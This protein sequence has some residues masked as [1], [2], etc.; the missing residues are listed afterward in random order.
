MS[1]KLVRRSCWRGDSAD[2]E[3]CS[4][5]LLS[6]VEGAG[7]DEDASEVAP[8]LHPSDET[9]AARPTD[10]AAEVAAG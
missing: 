3:S 2:A 7:R 10:A 4:A 6:V 9:S 5:L 8:M 1:S